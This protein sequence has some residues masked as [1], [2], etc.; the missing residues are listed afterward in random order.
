MENASN[1]LLISGGILV[2]MLI[3]A[4]AVFIFTTYSGLGESYERQLSATEIQKF[5]E[6][7]IKYIGRNN[8]KI[9]E[10]VSITNFA[11]EYNDKYGTSIKVFVD[12]VEFTGN[13]DLTEEVK[14]DNNETSYI[15]SDGDIHYDSYGMV[16]YIKFTKK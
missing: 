10:I 15:V 7:F 12:I 6:N 16:E 2:A 1:A 14:N 3:I 13:I 11:K 8:I 5:N 9:Q 4:T